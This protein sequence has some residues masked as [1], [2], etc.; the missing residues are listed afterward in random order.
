MGGQLFPFLL[1]AGLAVGGCPRVSAQG[2]DLPQPAE[3]TTGSTLFDY[4]GMPGHKASE[5]RPQT[6]SERAR[7][8]ARGL[9]NPFPAVMAA[10]EAGIS[11][12]EDV[13]RD[14]GQGARGYSHRFGDYL[15]R[16]T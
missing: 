12:A 15:A 8:Y 10:A 14:W 9:I 7:F 4:L 3:D 13:P 5:F 1:A 11:Q 6:Q 16:L 2:H